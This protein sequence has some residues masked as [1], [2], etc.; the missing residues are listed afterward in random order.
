MKVNESKESIELFTKMYKEGLSN[1]EIGERFSIKPNTVCYW[2]KKLGLKMKGS[3][4]KNKFSNPFEKVSPE[5]DYWLGYIFADGHVQ[6]GVIDLYSVDKDVI[7]AYRLFI[8]NIG[9]I[10]S[11]NYQISS[12]EV[13]T[14][15]KVHIYSVELSEWFMQEFNISSTKH[16][17]LNPTIDINWDI[18]RGYFDGDG[19]A[20]KVRG[21]TLNSSSKE[22]IDRI[23]DFF[24]DELGIEP[25]INQYIDCYKL[26][27]WGKEE[28]QDLI[29]K[30]YKHNT[31]CIQRKKIRFEPFLSNEIRKQG[32][33]REIWDDNPQ[34]S[35]SLTTCEGSETNS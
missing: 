32:E 19:S 5:R 26:C 20:H 17:N 4:R 25:K 7:D 11:E 18:I 16:H 15:Y 9:T 24:I 29:P 33:L 23:S 1:K 6:R 13:H 14:I 28:L 8:N 27:V 21:F 31:F 22:W 34:P 30:L 35:T 10:T 2:V 3:G 12:G